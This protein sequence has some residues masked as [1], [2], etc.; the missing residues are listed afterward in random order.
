MFE[1]PDVEVEQLVWAFFN[2]NLTC[3][4][5]QKKMEMF[6]NVYTAEAL[7]KET[8]GLIPDE[9][10]SQDVIETAARKVKDEADDKNTGQGGFFEAANDVQRDDAGSRQVQRRRRAPSSERTSAPSQSKGK[11]DAAARPAPEQANKQE[12]IRPSD[13]NAVFDPKKVELREDTVRGVKSGRVLLK[14][15][16]TLRQS[17]YD[18]AFTDAGVD[19][20]KAR[21]SSPKDQFLILQKLVT[22]KFSFS[23]F[24]K[25]DSNNYNAVQ[26]LL[27]AYRNLQWM[28]HIVALPNTAFGLDGSL[29]LYKTK[30]T[31]FRS[32]FNCKYKLD[33]HHTI[34]NYLFLEIRYGH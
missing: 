24:E 34:I 14:E 33:N 19:P 30:G 32:V 23:Y 28:T 5:S 1:R 31:V 6:L 15:V 9:T 2:D 20:R 10:I 16:E 26:A 22:K 3:A 11:V 4:N 17:L 29:G 25:S 13:T 7:L 8:S 12:N 27:D 18:Q 21:N